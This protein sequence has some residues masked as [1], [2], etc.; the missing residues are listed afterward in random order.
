MCEGTSSSLPG[1]SKNGSDTATLEALA[2]REAMAYCEALALAADLD[3]HHILIVSD[4][5]GVVNDI[6]NVTR[7]VYASVS[8]EIKDTSDSFDCTFTF[9]G[10]TTNIKAHSL[11]NHAFG[12]DLYEITEFHSF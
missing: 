5:E 7:G 10:R 3:L 12:L 2:Y 8:R 9:K 4:C 1:L 6:K 11:A